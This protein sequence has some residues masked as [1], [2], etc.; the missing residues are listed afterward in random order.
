MDSIMEDTE[1]R[2]MK[3]VDVTASEFGSIRTGRASPALLERLHVNYYG[4]M[5]PLNQLA[6]IS[7]PEPRLLV[8]QPYDRTSIQEIEKAITQ[9]D[10][11]FV[12]SDDGEV[13]RVP[14]PQLTEERRV[15]LTKLVKHRAEEGRVA[16]RNIRR[17]AVEAL[18]NEEKKGDATKDDLHRGVEEIQ[19]LTDRYIKEIDELAEKKS[20]E[21]MEI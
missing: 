19:K 5:T 21:L 14:V 16:I 17:E 2:F 8:I 11:G 18:R 6:T 15:E 10:L 7:A 3:A 9:S 1:Y 4:A 13:I 12:P 20:I